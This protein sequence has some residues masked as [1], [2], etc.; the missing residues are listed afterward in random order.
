MAANVHERIS[1]MTYYFLGCFIVGALLPFIFWKARP[2]FKWIPGIALALAAF[3]Y[4]L[5]ARFFPA[6]ELG[7]LADFL[8][9]LTLA[10]AAV[11]SLIGGLAMKILK[12]RKGQ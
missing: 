9:F 1:N 12:Q 6:E 5:K 11:G 2:S 4:Y 7:A 8:V 10:E 3:L